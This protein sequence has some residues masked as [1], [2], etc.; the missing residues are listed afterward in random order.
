MYVYCLYCRTQRC[1]RIAGLLE[2]RGVRKAFSPTILQKQRVE[3]RN[4]FR[5]RDLL[6]GYVFLFHDERLTGRETFAGIDSAGQ[7]H[8]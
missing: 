3:G 2:I 7:R 6:P 8:C 5:R 1:A 4:V